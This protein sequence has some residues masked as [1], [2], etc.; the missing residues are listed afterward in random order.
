MKDVGDKNKRGITY[1]FLKLPLIICICII[2]AVLIT[3]FAHIIY[4]IFTD[5]QSHM[6]LK[7]GHE[8]SGLPLRPDHAG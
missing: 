6:S 3:W 5:A 4:T 8:R 2:N 7:S 1:Y